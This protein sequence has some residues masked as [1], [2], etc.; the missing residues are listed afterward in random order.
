MTGPAQSLVVIGSGPAAWTAAVYAARANLRPLVYEGA[1]SQANHTA[2]R[3]PL[4]QLNLA[5]EVENFPGFPAFPAVA[6][7]ASGCMAALDA[8]RWLAGVMG[9]GDS[10]PTV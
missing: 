9:R 6:A 2:G 4:G 7:A 3:L 1:V 8:E 5:K 10:Q